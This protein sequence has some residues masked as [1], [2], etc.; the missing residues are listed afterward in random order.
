MIYPKNLKQ[1]LD[2][3]STKKKTILKINIT[4]LCLLQYAKTKITLSLKEV[5]SSHNYLK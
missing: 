2:L 1:N 3:P 4:F 5:S